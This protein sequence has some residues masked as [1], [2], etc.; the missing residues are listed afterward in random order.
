MRLDFSPLLITLS[1][2]RKILPAPMIKW[3]RAA[4]GEMGNRESATFI[5]RVNVTMV[6]ARSRFVTNTL[7]V[8]RLPFLSKDVVHNHY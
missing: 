5:N 1:K 4:P 2:Q 6:W 7:K 3:A 8:K